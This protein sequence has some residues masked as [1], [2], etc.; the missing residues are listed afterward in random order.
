MILISVLKKIDERGIVR[1]TN[2]KKYV[3]IYTHTNLKKK[4]L[5]KGMGLFKTVTVLC[6]ILSLVWRPGHSSGGKS[7]IIK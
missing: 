3:K 1:Y 4:S 2:P 5:K 7:E 6:S